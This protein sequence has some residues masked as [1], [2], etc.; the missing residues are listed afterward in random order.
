M[1]KHFWLVLIILTAAGCA[2]NSAS[3]FDRDKYRIVISIRDQTLVLFDRDIARKSYVVSSARNGASEQH[4][5]GGTPRGLHE[6]AEKFGEGAPLGMVF[7]DRVPT[8]EIVEKNT[9]GRAPVTTR[10]LRLKGRES[11]NAST[12][13]RLIYIHGSPVEDL[14]GRPVSGGCIRMRSVDVGELFELVEVGT[15]VEIHE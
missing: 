1:R 12:F 5:S 2:T 3:N 7:V 9:V 4:G 15:I 10:I 6:I 11:H 13:E 14:L 8:G